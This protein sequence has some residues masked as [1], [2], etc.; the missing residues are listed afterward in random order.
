MKTCN[1]CKETKSFSDFNKNRCN[2]D[3]Y[4]DKC[5]KCDN[6]RRRKYYKDNKSHPRFRRYAKQRRITEKKW[7]IE[8][9]STLKC[10]KCPENHPGCLD[11]HHLDGTTKEFGIASRLGS[12]YKR[13]G[14]LEEIDKCIVL[15]SNCH[16]KLH[17]EE[18]HG[19]LV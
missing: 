11:F 17:W 16:R 2:K 7:W 18:K 19:P 9:K 12:T 10:S 5:R 1:K 4:Q 14:I 6:E 15:C 13:E 8:Y 3:G